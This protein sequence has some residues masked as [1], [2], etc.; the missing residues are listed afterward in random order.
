MI[1]KG[2]LLPLRSIPAAYRMTQKQAPR[3]ASPYIDRVLQPLLLFRSTVDAVLPGDAG[4]SV[5]RRVAT[6]VSSLWI[7]EVE[8]LLQTEE[9]K[10]SALQRL[11]RGS[12]GSAQKQTGAG[13]TLTDFEKMK[14]QLF[15][16]GQTLGEALLRQLAEEQPQSRLLRT[17]FSLLDKLGD[18]TQKSHSG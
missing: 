3:C 7:E 2:R 18:N 1:S 15:L 13:G 10:E 5:L 12:V 17:H 8:L 14:L 6:M 16:D 4:R 11:Q 9:R